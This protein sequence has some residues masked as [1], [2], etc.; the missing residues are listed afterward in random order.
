MSWLVHGT[1]LGFATLSASRSASWRA[2]FAGHRFLVHSK[3]PQLM[4]HG[5]M[6]RW[7]L[8]HIIL[9]EETGYISNMFSAHKGKMDTVPQ[10]GMTDSKGNKEEQGTFQ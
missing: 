10:L 4:R 9:V 5:G 7:S 6:W 3:E 8:I 2:T 1:V